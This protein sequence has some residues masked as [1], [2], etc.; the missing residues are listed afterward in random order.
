MQRPD[1]DYVQVEGPLP[2]GSVVALACPLC[3]WRSE[4]ATVDE[5]VNGTWYALHG[6]GYEYRKHA[7]TT[8]RLPAIRL[9][10]AADFGSQG[11]S[12]A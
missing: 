1:G 9:G 6:L 3:D 12:D 2:A 4:P 5:Q 11:G 7:D 10:L 8:H